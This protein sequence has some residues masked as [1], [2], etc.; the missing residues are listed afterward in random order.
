MNKK[1]LIKKLTDIGLKIT[2][3]RL[4]VIDALIR[5]KN[6]PGAETIIEN[7]RKKHPN[8]SPAT[9]YKTLELF[10][11][12]GIIRK[13]KTDSE[14]MRYDAVQER[15]H[16]LY[17]ADSDRIEDYYDNDLDII[18]SEYFK[19]KNIPGFNVT[20]FKLQITGRFNRG[21]K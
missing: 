20:E 2:P 11:S 5:L 13:V 18:L 16:H 15:H 1:D 9:I 6:H 12:K 21:K 4:S 17:C 14:L 10:V 8:I 7:I 3:Q 19:K